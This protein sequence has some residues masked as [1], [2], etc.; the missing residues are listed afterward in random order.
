MAYT[1]NHCS[2]CGGSMRISA[3]S[4]G[5]CGLTYG[6]DFYTPRLY[7]LGADD[8]QFVELFVLASG[9]L[10]QM[11]QLL[12]VSYPTVRNRLNKLI[13]VLKE[14]KQKDEIRK[15]KI[16]EDIEAGRISAKQGMRMIDAI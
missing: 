10:K 8:Q 11:A 4:C 12:G 2:Y 1:H 6:G 16:L 3:L 7:R 14:E 5:D 15:Q 9:S 13:G